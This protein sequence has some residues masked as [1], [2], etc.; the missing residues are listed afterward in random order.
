MLFSTA[1]SQ[2]N[3]STLTVEVEQGLISLGLTNVP[4]N[5]LPKS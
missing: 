5:R 1:L 2:G 3:V 4:S